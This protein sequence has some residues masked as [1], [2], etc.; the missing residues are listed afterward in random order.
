MLALLAAGEH[1]CLGDFGVVDGVTGF[2]PESESAPHENALIA[3]LVN[4][5]DNVVIENFERRG[6]VTGPLI[7]HARDS[8]GW[9]ERA[10]DIWGE[11]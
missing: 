10:R 1:K 9:A 6:S 4:D 8:R 5:D 11:R 2:E 3:A 7:C